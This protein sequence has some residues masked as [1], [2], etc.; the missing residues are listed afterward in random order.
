MA[1]MEEHLL[2]IAEGRVQADG[3]DRNDWSLIVAA[4][5]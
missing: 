4:G 1:A 2:M 3:T 5:R